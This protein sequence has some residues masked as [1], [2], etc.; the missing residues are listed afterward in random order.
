VTW[1][2]VVFPGSNNDRDTV[3]VLR[4]VVGVDVVEV[5]HEDRDL[6]GVDAVVLPGGFAYG[7]YLR[8]GA[9]AATAPV[10]HAVRGFAAAGGPV[11]GI[12]NGFQI[13]AEARLLPGTLVRNAGLRFRCRSVWVRVESQ[14]TPFTATIPAGTVLQMPIAHGEGGY[15]APPGGIAALEAAGCVV[16]RYCDRAGRVTPEANPNG[17]VGAVAGVA[18]AAGNVVGLMPHPE[19]A[20]EAVLGSADGLRLF[21]SA[22]AWLRERSAGGRRGPDPGAGVSSRASRAPAGARRGHAHADGSL[23]AQREEAR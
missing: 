2:V 15:V 22:V 4:H 16:F 13:L 6:A 7:D 12:C 5:W 9:I 10:M 11:L 3:H 23:A 17:S 14:R 1:G 20:A 21:A 19:R 8:A 18:N